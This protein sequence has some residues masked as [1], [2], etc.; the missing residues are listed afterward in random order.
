MYYFHRLFYNYPMK[1]Y[2]LENAKGKGP[3]NVKPGMDRCLSH[4]LTPYSMN[5]SVGLTYSEL[6]SLL[7][8]KKLAFGW[9]TKKQ[10]KDFFPRKREAITVAQEMGFKISVYDAVAVLIFPDGQ[11]LFR[12]PKEKPITVSLEEFFGMKA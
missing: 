12:K 8:N 4:H 11:I 1:I 2:R 10:M 5:A 6:D 3:F 9:K 7:M